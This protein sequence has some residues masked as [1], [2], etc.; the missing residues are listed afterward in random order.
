MD[1]GRK[2][3]RARTA[4]DTEF[5]A[6]S[7]EGR[8]KIRNLGEGGLFVTTASVPPQG[9]S[10]QVRFNSPTEGAMELSG[11]VWWTTTRRHPTPGFGVRLLDADD[12]YQRLV[13]GLLRR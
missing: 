9:E 3:R 10:V 12:R 5:R 8:G 2:S 6:G 4:F 11:L 13:R 7:I 1:Q